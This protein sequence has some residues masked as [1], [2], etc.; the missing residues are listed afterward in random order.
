MKHNKKRL[1]KIIDE[2]TMYLF[3]TGATNI[4]ISIEDREDVYVIL[5]KSNYNKDKKEKIVKL[6]EALKSPRQEEMEEYYWELAG[7]SDV[8]SEMYLTGMMIN[9]EHVDIDDNMLEISLYK[10][11]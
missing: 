11:K 4:N 8:G 7:E 10:N 6:I 9:I 3:S 2:L 5:I 1:M